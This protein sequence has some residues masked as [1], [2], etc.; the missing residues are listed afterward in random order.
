M[1]AN[2]QTPENREILENVVDEVGH[3]AGNHLK[4]CTL[5]TDSNGMITDCD[6]EI[7]AFLGFSPFDV[8]G[9]PFFSFALDT[10]EQ[11]KLRDKINSQEFPLE[12]ELNYRS[13][14]NKLINIIT[15]ITSLQTSAGRLEGFRITYLSKN[16]NDEVDTLIID[17]DAQTEND[18][19]AS[20][21]NI[22]TRM[23]GESDIA[24]ENSLKNPIS[25]PTGPI[26][27]PKIVKPR[28]SKKQKAPTTGLGKGTN[29]LV[30]G[31]LK[32]KQTGNLSPAT[33]TIQG[34]SL[35]NAELSISKKAWTKQ[36]KVTLEDNI[37]VTSQGGKNELAA[38]TVP[39]V[40]Q[41]ETSGVLEIVDES[42]QRK[43]SSDEK[44]L[45][46]E[47]ANQLGLALENAQ[48]YS[49]V[50]K[51]LSD[52]VRAEEETNRRNA[53]LAKLNL[54]IQRL[55]RLVS[56]EEIFD[57]ISYSTQDLM[58]TNNILIST[59]D[60]KEAIIEFPVCLVD[61]TRVPIPGRLAGDG[62]LETVLW[63]QRPQ[64]LNDLQN[65]LGSQQLDHPKGIPNSMLAVP[66]VVGDRSVG[67]L[68]VFD[69]ER[70]SAFDEIQSE[71]LSTVAGQAGTALENTRLFQEI[72]QALETIENRERY[73]TNVTN[74]VAQLS[75]RGS[76]SI[77]F[78][79][80]SMAKAAR[81]ERI[82]YLV[83]TRN[84]NGEYEWYVE[85]SF[86]NNKSVQTLPKAA[87]VG[88]EKWKEALFS[89][90][91]ISSS[92]ISSDEETN[93][94]TNQFGALSS[95]FLP[96][97]PSDLQ[98]TMLLIENLNQ[99]YEWQ[100]EEID[101]LRIATDALQNTL[102]REELLVQIQSSLEETE[103]LYS[104][105]HSLALATTLPEMVAAVMKSVDVSD[106]NRGILVLFEETPGAELPK[107]SVAANFYS[108]MGTPPPPVGTDYLPELYSSIFLGPDPIFFDDVSRSNMSTQLINVLTNQ[109]IRSMGILP[110][111]AGNTHM[112]VMLVCSTIQH[113][114]SLQ[115]TRT[116]P[117][118]ADQL[119]TAIQNMRLFEQ[120][121][122]ALAETNL[123][124]KVSSGIANAQSLDEYLKIVGE[125]ALPEQADHIFLIST[126]VGPENKI[127][128]CTLVGYFGQPGDYHS[129]DLIIEGDSLSFI[130][131]E[132]PNPV[133]I[134]NLD[135]SEIPSSLKTIFSDYGLKTASFIPLQTSGNPVGVIVAGSKRVVEFAADE[136]QTIQIIGNSIAV[137][138]ERRRLLEEAQRR[139]LELQTA[140]EIARDT[141]ST[142]SFNLLLERIVNLLKER[143][144]IYHCSI[145][146]LNEDR[147]AA[148]VA[149]STGL[150]GQEMKARRHQ[151][152]VGSKSVIGS[153]TASGEIF[154][155]NDVTENPNYY[156]N[157]LLPE[158]RSEIG[159]P[160]KISGKVIG[161][162]DLQDSSANA[163]SEDEIKVF[164]I[165]ADQ[166]AVAVE[167]A[168]AFEVSQEA[169]EEM[170]ELDR[171]KNQFLANMSHELRTPL[172]SVIGF[173]RVILKGIDGPINETQ[174]QDI[175]AIYNSG[176]HLL[177]MINE[178]LDMSKIE[179]GK[180]ELQ[181]EELNIS[182][183]INNV[184]TNSMGLVKDKPLELIQK[185]P[186]NLPNVKADES[187]INQVLINLISNAV[188]FTE[189][190]AITIEARQQQSLTQNWEIMVTVTDS[191][192]GISPE[193]QP[194]LFQRFS[195]VDDSPTRKT[196]GTGLGLSICRSL[197][198]LH[199]G[200]IGL[201]KSEVGKGSTFY[202]TLPIDAQRS[203]PISEPTF[204]K[205]KVILSIDDDDQVIG[206]YERFLQPLGY[207]VIALSD[208]AQAVSKA[209]EIQPFA[210]TL[211]IMMPIVDGWQVLNELK[212]D[213]ITRS[214]P[215]II[216]SILEEAEKGFSFGASDYLVKPFM[217]DE[218]IKAIQKLDS[219]GDIQEIM[220]VDDDPADLRLL[221]KM[222][223][224]S[225]KFTVVV[226]NGG[227]PALTILQDYTPDA[228][229][230][231]L[232]M[233]DINGFELLQY[234]K[235]NDRLHSVPVIILTGAD[236]DARQKEYLDSFTHFLLSKGSMD[237][238]SLLQSL[239][240]TL[241]SL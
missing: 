120:T 155:V 136:L 33:E 67:V 137:A 94:I 193:D 89:S 115:E 202:F 162:L 178:I 199:G 185:V 184:I 218:L 104:A 191:G 30:T 10:E 36:A 161:A 239:K 55:T 113:T 164:Q 58:Q 24:D 180:M 26:I 8:I 201:L 141:T 9:Q 241:E 5:K 52:R 223:E 139:A 196:G 205:D 226:A 13:R 133:T 22:N 163:F 233:P 227:K 20:D 27:Q 37:L 14:T 229:I 167:N 206:L 124:Y 93:R 123:L 203:E 31:S 108:G 78:L 41:N 49:A 166:V 175:T 211:D 238:Q 114:F 200:H 29:A 208:P 179:A 214:I 111:L 77:D 207:Q 61:G 64:L 83:A 138:M 232:F 148:V 158:T 216:C 157:P 159:I 47:V 187:R 91:Y 40:I 90:Q 43:W 65:T 50:Q 197:I 143:F 130:N 128:S 74:A 217:Q 75:E 183:L 101:I 34:L 116:V 234:F 60:E 59:F 71:L 95:L 110:L 215:V 173:S 125:N 145:F 82:S 122:E 48:L 35:R 230:L 21:G 231:D 171:V 121:Q 169:V 16:L 165:L 66:M 154:L 192:I 87:W 188:K 152:A 189:K 182:D 224:E 194:K 186:V 1:D 117:P 160:L 98:P 126:S 97:K 170:R 28:D 209:R 72:T 17:R 142:L 210:I 109:N 102:V 135:V 174:E 44:L 15:Q 88:S 18:Q 56:T 6:R 96:V 38:I 80:E 168:R 144:E 11:Q 195:Q 46:Q 3:D 4:E 70:E 42:H 146:L 81:S 221:Q 107:M 156:P 225:G 220:V 63:E 181:I 129:I 147:S 84:R 51:E 204:P 25:E 222:L 85:K 134:Q 54:V 32:P 212:K 79:L 177:N 19:A 119:S 132:D 69:Y 172:N 118:L 53:D 23:I 150:A 45:V 7:S 76:R 2:N 240:K 198:E 99:A 12:I 149:E 235:E 106:L 237:E 140:A 39:L 112:G 100:L 105:S 153:C 190:G 176:M 131:F 236:L 68:S 86:M 57:I 73:Q 151:L 92:S 219:Q 213:E 62:F 228:I 127:A 103:N